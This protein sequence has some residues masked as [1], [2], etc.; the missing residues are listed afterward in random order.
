[1]F[2]GGPTRYREGG[3]RGGQAQFSWDSIKDDKHRSYYLGA[4]AKF[5]GE[6]WYL[7]SAA[8]GDA[9]EAR[10]Q[11]ELAAVRAAD[12]ALAREAL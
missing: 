7:G 3:T 4:T 9:D 2:G 8:S 6:A 1:M 5:G 12:E 11:E 10:R